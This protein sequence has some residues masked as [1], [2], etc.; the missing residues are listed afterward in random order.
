MVGASLHKSCL[1]WVALWRGLGG[2]AQTPIGQLAGCPGGAGLGHLAFRAFG[3]LHGLYLG[4]ATAGYC[5]G[6]QSGPVWSSIWSLY[7][8]ES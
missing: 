6:V 2:F 4:P 7:G 8:T 5:N 1:D 3:V